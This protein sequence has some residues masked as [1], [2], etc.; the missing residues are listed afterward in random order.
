[1]ILLVRYGEIHLK[2]L[3]RPHFESLQRQAIKRALAE[4]PD[5]KVEKGYGRFYVTGISDGELPRAVEAI[6]K[7]FGLHS[8]S[9]VYKRQS[10]ARDRTR[11]GIYGQGACRIQQADR[12]CGESTVACGS[13]DERGA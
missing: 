12:E 5:A 13:D 1:M 6:T 8:L 9:D 4:F 10:H 2:G 7:V 3:N 11:K